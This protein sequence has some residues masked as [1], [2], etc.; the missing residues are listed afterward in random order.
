MAYLWIENAEDGRWLPVELIGETWVFS[1]TVPRALGESGDG[2]SVSRPTLLVRRGSPTNGQWVLL[3]GHDA[4]VRVN[5]SPMASVNRVLQD[6]DEI[7][8]GDAETDFWQR[9]FFSMAGNATVEPFPDSRAPACCAKCKR[10]ILVGEL[11]VR[12]PACGHWHHETGN[13]QCCWSLP[14]CCTRC[15]CRAPLDSSVGSRQAG[16]DSNTES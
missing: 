7:L 11:A 16:D 13:G 12:C 8:L 14:G 4:N 6:H 3:A 1:T 2:D 5:G 10:P 15:R 9:W